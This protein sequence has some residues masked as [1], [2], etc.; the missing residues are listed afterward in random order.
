MERSI[1]RKLEEDSDDDSD[2]IKIHTDPF[3]LTGL[4]ILDI[5]GPAADQA[6]SAEDPMFDF[7]ELE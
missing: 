3:D 5:D 1:Q 4:D 6:V 2:R 7:E